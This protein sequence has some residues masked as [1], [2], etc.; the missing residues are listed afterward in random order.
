[1]RKVYLDNV[2]A[3]AMV[4]FSLA[5]QAEQKA[6]EKLI[7]I[8]DSGTI[9]FLI[10]AEVLREIDRTTDPEKKA[11]LKKGVADLEKV[12]SDHI[13]LGFQNQ[14]LGYR[15]S[16]SCPLV[17]DIIDKSLFSVLKGEGLKSRDATHFMNAVHNECD[18]FLTTD[19][20][21]INRRHRIEA[22][23][24]SIRSIR[25]M[26]PSELLGEITKGGDAAETHTYQKL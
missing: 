5:E 2:I 24:K 4:G 19:P 20:D 10:S 3:C 11:K 8:A 21:F 25:I 1:M 7:P 13:V 26:K 16:I 14:D 15:G 9:K 18:V 6:L 12:E 17:T 23:S 22:L